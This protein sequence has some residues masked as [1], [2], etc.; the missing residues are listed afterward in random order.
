MLLILDEWMPLKPTK[1][2][3]KISSNFSIAG[4]K[5]STIF[6]S[7]CVFEEWYDQ[8]G[9]E[10]RHLADALIAH[11]S[12]QINITSIDAGHDKS[13]QEIYSLGKTLRV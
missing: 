10:A 5:T 6:C 7:Q 3:Q 8:L 4:A 13:I 2:D 11:D 9:C 1:T 12:H